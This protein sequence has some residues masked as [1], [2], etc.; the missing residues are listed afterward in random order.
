MAA[1]QSIAQRATPPTNDAGERVCGAKRTKRGGDPC[2]RPAGWN[3]NH[4]GYGTCRLHG[5]MMPNHVK[6]ALREAGQALM[7]V[8]VQ[9]LD[10][11]P[12]D[13]MLY[14]VR[15]F[16]ALALCFRGQMAAVPMADPRWEFWRELEREALNDQRAA[17]D[18]ALRA[19]VA[20][21]Q[22]RI[23][24]RTGQRIAAG[25]D[26]ALE[27]LGLTAEQRAGAVE[28]FV[29]RLQLMEQGDDDG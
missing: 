20:E 5:G 7:R 13:A 18:A 2:Q 26:D 12:L 23:A 6:A 10:V 25:L 17:S 27:P 15:R 14:T 24:E 1:G 3:T 16:S 11:N 19:G 21:R 22:V 4:P 9:E 28:R 29:T 8:D